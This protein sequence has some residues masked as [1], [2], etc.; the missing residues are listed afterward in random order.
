[1]KRTFPAN[2][3]G[4]IFYIDEDAFEL[5]HNYLDQLHLT[6]TGAEGNEIVA[7]IESRIREHFASRVE[8]GANVIVLADVNKVIETMG[9]PED[10]SESNDS[11][12]KSAPKRPFASINLPQ[13]KRL[14]R[15]EQNKI[16]GGVLSGV[17]KY[18]NWNVTILRLLYTVFT[19]VTYFWPCVFV[20][21]IAWMIIPPARTPRQRLEMNGE[22]VNVDTLGQA[23]M[24][25]SPTPPPYDG[26]GT[27]N[28][29]SSVFSILGKCIM[30]FLGLV[31]LIT[32]FGA[33]VLFMVILVGAI[34][35]AGFGSN[36]ILLGLDWPFFHS[37]TLVWPTVWLILCVSLFVVVVCGSIAWGAASVIFRT[38]GIGKSALVAIVILSLLLIAASIALVAMLN[39][40]NSL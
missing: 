13:N 22:P 32:G 37:L 40:L 31:S 12:E 34:A 7:D 30:G 18:F 28:F 17:A 14:F 29:F 15:D 33:L 24:A 20:Y 9:R 1:M 8:S 3:D 23:V 16:F 39:G 10:L 36:T 6:F 21:L 4:Q 2:I 27:E 25:D 38:K 35:Y 26:N 5:L 19:I 11:E